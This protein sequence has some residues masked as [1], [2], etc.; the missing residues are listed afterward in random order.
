MLSVQNIYYYNTVP[1]TEKQKI[2]T[3]T[4]DETDLKILRILQENANLTVKELAAKANLSTTPIFERQ[5]RLERNGYIKRYVALLDADKL[6][7]GFEVFC[8]VKLKQLNA[9]VAAEFTAA[10]Q[11]IPEVTECYNISGEFDYLLRVFAPNMK[12]YQEFVLNVL[13]RLDCMGSLQSVFVMAEIK[14]NHGFPI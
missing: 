14:R 8:N 7:R 11:D 1:M 6:N 2:F 4:L 5:K 3:D 12:Y 9:K 10:V 13:G